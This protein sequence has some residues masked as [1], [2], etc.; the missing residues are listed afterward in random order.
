VVL[1]RL[2]DSTSQ[3]GALIGAEGKILGL[4]TRGLVRGKPIVIPAATLRRVGEEL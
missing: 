2:T 1:I 3:V 4:N